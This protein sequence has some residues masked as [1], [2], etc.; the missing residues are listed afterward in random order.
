MTERPEI[1]TVL[2]PVA[3]GELGPTA[4]HEHIIADGY[5]SGNDPQKVLDDED[6]AVEEMKDLVRAGAGTVVEC[7]SRGL[8]PDPGA[9]R[10]IARASG[11]N[12]IASAG[13]YRRIVY[14]DYV[15]TETAEGLARR[16]I[17]EVEN[18]IAGTGVRPG[19]LAEFASHDEGEPDEHVEKVWRAAARTQLATGLPITTHCWV[20]KGADWEIEILTAEGVPPDKIVIGHLGANR[21]DMDLARRVLDTGVNV[22]VD[23]VGYDER[24]GFVDY[25]DPERAQLIKT[26]I[27]WSHLSQITISRDM[28]RKYALKKHGGKGYSY[29]F[30]GFTDILRENGIS[31]DEIHTLLVENPRR[32]L[33]PAG[34]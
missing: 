1:M 20:G 26:F 33:T 13:F 31:D 19:M 4:M 32:I 29:L 27:D 16:M 15:L 17:D 3:P 8:G 12:I 28:M 22:G 23:C 7:T 9:L 5:F 14:P 11:I 25:F 24:V 21:P 18:G 30:E 2:G 6:A 34:S 10:R